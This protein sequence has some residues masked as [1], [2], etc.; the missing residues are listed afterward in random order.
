MGTEAVSWE[1]GGAGG[2]GWREGAGVEVI[3][4]DDGALWTT[5]T[6]GGWCAGWKDAPLRRQ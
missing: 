4:G 2:G 1:D 5:L 6:L 3:G